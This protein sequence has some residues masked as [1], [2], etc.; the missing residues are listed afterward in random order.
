MSAEAVM[1][2][3][4]GHE[5]AAMNDVGGI[6]RRVARCALRTCLRGIALAL[7]AVG[8]LPLFALALASVAL[9]ASGLGF[10]LAPR[11]LLAVRWQANLERRRAL[12]WSGVTIASPYR[13]GPKPG[14]RLLKGMRR[15]S[16]V[17]TDPATWRDLLWTLAGVPVSVVLGF[18]PLFL[19]GMGGWVLGVDVGTVFGEVQG[20]APNGFL[21]QVFLLSFLPLAVVG[22][23]WL[24]KAHAQ[25]ASA[26][27]A[28]TRK[29]MAER[30][31][32]LTESRSTAVDTSAAELRRIERD[33]HDGAQAR[34]VAVGMNIGFAEQVVKDDPE[35]ALTLL[36]EARTSSGEALSELRALVRGIHPPVLAERGLSGAVAALALSLPL[37]VDVH[38]NLPG[39]GSEPVESAAYFAIAEALANVVK[40]SG[41]TRAWVQ[42]E[43][44][45]GTLESAPGTMV[46]IVGDNGAGGAA[47][48]D[49]G[50]LR[51]I[52]RRLS[53]FDGMVA[54]TSPI[55]GPT[56][57]TMELPCELSSA[58][59]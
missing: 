52:E 57:V 24:L 14:H 53:A 32:Q 6:A 40:H 54:V 38:V 9:I 25:V 36:A 2:D 55:G 49:G 7:T 39:R 34:L 31:S 42:L 41:A 48:R 19:L 51:G 10:A 23:P 1:G 27:L 50:G 59:T 47:P 17:L 11:A 37:P 12:E 5:A 29:E 8:C 21:L 33:L 26:L 46:A 35:L 18:L 43:Y 3:V 44:E 22:G 28:P 45:A 16:W 30:V 20:L 13:P 58:R 15:F 56:Q 4:G